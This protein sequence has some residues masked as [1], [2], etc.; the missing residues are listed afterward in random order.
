MIVSIETSIGVEPEL[1]TKDLENNLFE[2]I[3]TLYKNNCSQEYGYILDI[4]K[5]ERILDNYISSADSQLLIKLIFQA[6]TLLPQIGN[7]YEGKVSMLREN[8]G[9]FV[10]IA[11]KFKILI[12][13]DQLKKYKF[14]NNEMCFVYKDKKIQYADNI[15]VKILR[16]R[17]DA[18]KKYSILGEL[19]E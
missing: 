5:I 15:R 4:I 19:I 12:S 16:L 9:I 7:I 1:L 11:N 17:Y 2:K 3:K 8:A 13:K 6:E 10:D 18:D 14:D